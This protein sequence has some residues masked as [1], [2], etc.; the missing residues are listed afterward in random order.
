MANLKVH[1]ITGAAVG[2]SLNI[3]KQSAQKTLNPKRAFSFGELA[4]WSAAGAAAASLPDILEPALTPLHRRFFHSMA[5]GGLIVFFIFGKPARFLRKETHEF[6]SVAGFG[7][8]SHLALDIL[9]PM[10]LPLW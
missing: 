8:L 2:A 5:V 1:L 9:T 6:F 4:V 10:G 7:Y 3:I